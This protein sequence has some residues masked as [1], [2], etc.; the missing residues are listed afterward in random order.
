[1]LNN[2]P[3][4][5]HHAFIVMR[6]QPLHF[7]HTYLIDQ[8]LQ[9]AK[10][11]SIVLGSSQ[12]SRT[13]KNP[14][15]LAERLQMLQN[16]YPPSSNLQI[17]GIPDIPNDAEWYDFV[18]S[19]LRQHHPEFPPVDAF[20]CGGSF[21]G[22]WFTNQQIRIVIIDRTQQ[23]GLFNISATQIRQWIKQQNPQWQ[24][25]VPS[26]NLSLIQQLLPELKTIL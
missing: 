19:S 4:L 6:A 15:T 8:M 14:F 11:C 9:Q 1:M 21:E 25:Y 20:Y 10:Y 24:H 7:G 18:M 12:E 26:V 13:A 22:S 2:N 3:K 23:T 16:L 17:F 5:F